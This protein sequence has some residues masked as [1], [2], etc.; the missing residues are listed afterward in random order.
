[1]LGEVDLASVN[2]FRSS[3][4]SL[5]NL[6]HCGFIRVHTTPG[7]DGPSGEAGSSLDPLAR[8]GQG[9]RDRAQPRHEVLTLDTE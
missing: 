9:A 1:M 6:Y 7:G 8:A 4:P 5:P 2:Q 3:A